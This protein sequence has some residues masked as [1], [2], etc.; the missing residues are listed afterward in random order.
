VQR[1]TEAEKA[2]IWDRRSEGVGMRTVARELAEPTGRCGPWS[3]ITAGF[4]LILGSGRLV[5][6]R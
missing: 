6:C 3:K 4:D 2:L 1:F 5:I